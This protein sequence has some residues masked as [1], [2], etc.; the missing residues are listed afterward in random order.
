MGAFVVSLDF[1]LFWGVRDVLPLHEYRD[2]LLGERLAVTALLERFTQR[3]VRA[4]WATVGALFC[5]TREELLAAMPERRPRYLERRQSPYE[6]LDEIG[7]DERADPVH[8]GASLVKAIASASGQ[9]LATHTFSHFYCLE[10][11]QTA[12]DFDAD[13]ATAQRLA[14]PFGGVR[15]LVFPRN[16]YNPAYRNVL[17]RRAIR[18][19]RSNGTYWAYA[20]STTYEPPAKR[21][22]R[23]ADAYLPISGP[24]T[25]RVRKDGDGLVDVPASAFLRPYSHRLRHLDRVRVGRIRR[26]MSHA[27][28]HD[29]CFHLWWHPH[30]FGVN[31][32]E[33]MAVLDAILDH[34]DVLRRKGR[35]ESKHMGDFA[36]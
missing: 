13:L 10:P 7:A 5:A 15:S 36:A 31:L 24:H 27:A 26:A 18:T 16:Q 6:A 14:Q 20:P 9:E 8:F 28:D 17:V 2:N 4:T 35:L 29:E 34:F 33:N 11:G 23:L 25:H 30:N 1:E 3:G 22:V 21:A 19:Y 32:R 12:D